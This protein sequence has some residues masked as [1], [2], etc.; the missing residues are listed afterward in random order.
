MRRSLD[1]NRSLRELHVE[2]PSR[3]RSPKSELQSPL[4]T[5]FAFSATSLAIF[6]LC[7]SF[8]VAFSAVFELPEG[9]LRVGG[10]RGALE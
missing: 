5:K 8:R 10:V 6:V 2:V 4:P 9:L 3:P 7:S 1:A